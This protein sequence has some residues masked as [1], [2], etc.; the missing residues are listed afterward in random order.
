MTDVRT[1]EVKGDDLQKIQEDIQQLNLVLGGEATAESSS[2][3]D[4]SDTYEEVTNDSYVDREF[5]NAGLSIRSVSSKGSRIQHDDSALSEDEVDQGTL[6]ISLEDAYVDTDIPASPEYCLQLNLAYQRWIEENLKT[7]LDVKEK[8]SKRQEAINAELKGDSGKSSRRNKQTLFSK[9]F[10]NFFKDDTGSIPVP[11]KETLARRQSGHPNVHRS[12]VR[13]WTDAEKECL[14]K[15]VCTDGKKQQI[16]PLMNKLE[17]LQRKLPKLSKAESE[18]V[19]AGIENIEIHIRQISNRPDSDFVGKRWQGRVDWDKIS[20]IDFDGERT[21]VECE[22]AWQNRFHTSIKNSE[23]SKEEDQKLISL[24]EKHKATEWNS[25]AEN[26]GTRRTAWQCIERYQQHLNP[27][28]EKRKFTEEDDKLMVEVIEKLRIGSKIPYTK[29]AYFL[30]GSTPARVYN[31]W[32]HVLNPELKR[33]KWTEEED[34]L[35]RQG[36][37]MYGEKWTA[38]AQLIPGRISAQIRE[39]WLN[40]L[41]PEVKRG[42]WE[43]SEDQQ[44]LQLVKKHGTGNWVKISKEMDSGRTPN[45]ILWRYRKLTGAEKKNC[46][47]PKPAATKGKRRPSRPK[48][49]PSK[50]K[51]CNL[52]LSQKVVYTLAEYMKI[53]VMDLIKQ[54]MTEHKQV[55]TQSVLRKNQSPPLSK[56]EKLSLLKDNSTLEQILTVVFNKKTNESRTTQTI[57]PKPAALTTTTMTTTT[58]A[59]STTTTTSN[60]A[61]VSRKSGSGKTTCTQTD[62]RGRGRKAT[63]FLDT[64][65]MDVISAKTAKK[66][67]TR[68][69]K[70]SKV[71]KKPPPEQMSIFGVLVK[72]LDIDIPL[73]SS[74]IPGYTNKEANRVQLPKNPPVIQQQAVTRQPVA[75]AAGQNQQKSTQQ[76]ASTPA[77]QPP[78]VQ[79]LL[80]VTRGVQHSKG[81][82]VLLAHPGIMPVI[83]TKRQNLH[84]PAA[85]EPPLDVS[86]Q[87]PPP[88]VQTSECV[89]DAT[90]AHGT[91]SLSTSTA[92][93]PTSSTPGMSN[94]VSTEAQTPSTA[95]TVAATHILP[96]SSSSL[97][98]TS[99]AVSQSVTVL[100]VAANLSSSTTA[101]PA[102]VQTSSTQAAA[103]VAANLL[104][105]TAAAT[106]VPSAPTSQMTFSACRTQAAATVAANLLQSTAPTT[107]PSAP[108]LQVTFPTSSTQA[109]ASVAANLLQPTAATTVPSAPAS[110][111]TVPTSSTQAVA[112]AA[113]LLQSTAAPTVLSV[114]ESQVTIPTS[115]TQAVATAPSVSVSQT[116]VPN[117]A[118]AVISATPTSASSTASVSV[119]SLPVTTGKPGIQMTTVEE[120]SIKNQGDTTSA[121]ARTPAIVAPSDQRPNTIAP[122]Q[123]SSTTTTT[124]NTSVTVSPSVRISSTALLKSLQSGTAILVPAGASQRPSASSAGPSPVSA[125]AEKKHIIIIKRKTST[126]ATVQTVNTLPAVITA[127]STVAGSALTSVSAAATSDKTTCVTASSAAAAMTQAQGTG[128][129]GNTV[130]VST[131]NQTQQ[132]SAAIP[133]GKDSPSG[134]SPKKTPTQQTAR[135]RLSASRLAYMSSKLTVAELL[136]QKRN[137]KRM[138]DIAAAGGAVVLPQF[139]Q[140]P[141]GQVLQVNPITG[142]AVVL[143]S[144]QQASVPVTK[145][146]T[147]CSVVPASGSNPMPTSP[148]QSTSASVTCAAV[149]VPQSIMS[150]SLSTSP[151]VTQTVTPAAAETE[152]RV[153]SGRLVLSTSTTQPE[154]VV[155]A[156]TVTPATPATNRTLQLNTTAS[157][158]LP[159]TA[160]SNTIRIIPLPS[161]IMTTAATPTVKLTNLPRPS[162]PSVSVRPLQPVGPKPRQRFH[163][164]ALPPSRATLQTFHELKRQQHQ[165]T[166]KATKCLAEI[167][168]ATENASSEADPLESSIASQSQTQES[169]SGQPDTTRETELQALNSLRQSNSY[170]MLKAR[171]TSLFSWP[172]LLSR[173]DAHFSP[174]MVKYHVDKIQ[175]RGGEE[176]EGEGRELEAQQKPAK[177][178]SPPKL[179]TPAKFR[180]KSEVGTGPSA[181]PECANNVQ[182]ANTEGEN[183]LNREEGQLD[184]TDC[185][186][187]NQVECNVGGTEAA[188]GSSVTSQ[189][190]CGEKLHNGVACEGSATTQGLDGDRS[191]LIQEIVNDNA[192]TVQDT[193][194]NES[195]EKEQSTEAVYGN[196]DQETVNTVSC[197]DEN[198]RRVLNIQGGDSTQSNDTINRKRKLDTG[199]QDKSDNI[200]KDGQD[201]EENCHGDHSAKRKKIHDS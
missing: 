98:E 82:P 31:R 113:N 168:K 158:A 121:S 174:A 138:Q 133:P 175:E 195:T 126:P 95:P 47:Q 65:I 16:K 166:S 163:V 83:Q 17:V 190:T 184:G 59:T 137:K 109:A 154:R 200:L 97:T 27:K 127:T 134:T 7:L 8:N 112:T 159:M 32:H 30:E 81:A 73:A 100:S 86:Q 120:V 152:Q 56:A 89:P 4:D 44:M 37:Q 41:R 176:G 104:Q 80:P 72:A 39:H 103:T 11:N 50:A 22:L 123:L 78:Q 35:L 141:T 107:V 124:A 18:T 185:Q 106:T 76:H 71:N 20:C 25:I 108:A 75:K 114:P 147:V 187:Q 96:S 28:L 153:P 155:V 170:K 54:L 156:A 160:T 1:Q 173:V 55:K 36:I 146:T 12:L 172:A 51:K 167:K 2:E 198:S 164:P 131:N 188:C 69:L 139:V 116:V 182:T 15:A 119:A 192:R 42:K 199:S 111:V 61:P 197:N 90:S 143:Q 149:T 48:A 85:T 162:S 26:L 193:A 77:A 63:K 79:L 118:I 3:E 10:N 62:G 92:T 87:G 45:S 129:S 14:Y 150:A 136:E 93:L 99:A 94:P 53:G 67:P 33:G 105:P 115:S 191:V 140:T 49:G 64:A 122:C 23:W 34:E 157:T 177:K 74:K 189:Q 60:T 145:A 181:V 183:T 186:Q 180:K 165:L 194:N 169:S 6:N 91:S 171:F 66:K 40:S 84:V 9:Y 68:P 29:V 57:I 52:R 161:A 144:N 24:V 38:I 70:F 132:P 117:S 88:I 130:T 125:S 101:S 13:K 142:A 179:R 58:I 21:A 201:A 135:Q 178:R 46:D 102:I 43:N 148:R 151:V 110:Q 128:S 196:S 5:R 19:M